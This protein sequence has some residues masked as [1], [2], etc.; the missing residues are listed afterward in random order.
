MGKI[1]GKSSIGRTPIAIHTEEK[2]T[3]LAA[4]KDDKAAEVKAC[5]RKQFFLKNIAHA[6]SNDK[7]REVTL[8]FDQLL[9]SPPL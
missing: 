7:R 4:K 6:A 3:V 1:L 2:H 5:V 9:C 8:H